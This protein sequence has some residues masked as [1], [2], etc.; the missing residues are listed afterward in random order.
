MLHSASTLPLAHVMRKEVFIAISIGLLIGFVIV[1][2]IIT[3]QKALNQQNGT[4]ETI[5]TDSTQPAPRT[6]PSDGKPASNEPTA[7]SKHAVSITIPKNLFVSTEAEISLKGTTTPNSH[8]AIT[9]EQGEFVIDTTETGQFLQK[10]QLIGGENVIRAVSF[11]P[12]LDR[13]ET[14]ITVIYTT[15]E[16]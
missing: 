14:D 9:T 3:A 8:V 11:S 13:A 12:E 7:S 4:T 16:F 15:A 5:A 10:I 6:S 1:F 2:G